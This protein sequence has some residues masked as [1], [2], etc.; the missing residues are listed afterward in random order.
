[1]DL[2][3]KVALVTGASRGIGAA[4]AVALAAA[5]ADV[6]C[7]ARS[8]AAAP[9]RV[10]GT[11]DD[12]VARIEALGGKAVAV[13]ADLAVDDDV[14]AMVR[15]VVE[16]FGRVDVL[17]NNAG[18][19]FFGDL[20]IDLARYDVTLAIN[21][22]APLIATREVAPIMAT[23][24]GG[25]ILN[26]SS[27]AAVLPQPK[28]LAYGI[29]KAGLERLSVDAAQLLQGDGTAVNCL[30]VDMAVASEGFVAN[31][32]GMDRTGWESCEAAADAIVWMLR[33]PAT[34]TGQIE[35]L[36]DL[37]QRG[38]LSSALTPA[39]LAVAPPTRL[40]TGLVNAAEAGVP[41]ID[42]TPTA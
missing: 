4:T 6:A 30:R 27:L 29:A 11:L 33:Q 10:P 40:V 32:P 15:T 3:D 2:K 22:R 16:N 34:Y 26:V 8:T 31:T 18:V 39:D 37:R 23:N 36:F 13:P 20:D 19:T 41:V 12:T 42:D 7:A 38:L 9:K 25:A 28:I 24:G 5:G 17:V 35:S 14:V 1:V 21:L